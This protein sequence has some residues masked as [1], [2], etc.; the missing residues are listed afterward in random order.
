MV[1]GRACGATLTTLNAKKIALSSPACWLPQC[2]NRLS[3]RYDSICGTPLNPLSAGIDHQDA[4]SSCQRL[5]RGCLNAAEAVWRRQLAA[6][7]L[8]KLL[9]SLQK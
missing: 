4:P 5:T 3:A 2:S 8:Q 6:Q 9:K 1:F 7:T